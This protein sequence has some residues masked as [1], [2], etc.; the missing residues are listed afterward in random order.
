MR[1]QR[2]TNNPTKRT[3]TWRTT[4]STATITAITEKNE[5]H[6]YRTAAMSDVLGHEVCDAVH[7]LEAVP[8]MA[9]ALAEALF[10]TYWTQANQQDGTHTQCVENS[11]ALLKAAKAAGV[12]RIVH[13]SIT[14]ADPGSPLP[15]FRSKGQIEEALRGLGVS[16]AILRPSVQYAA[17]DPFFNH[18]AWT[19]RRFPSVLLPSRSEF[20]LRPI[21]VQDLAQLAAEAAVQDKNLEIDAVGPEVFTY[22][23]MVRLGRDRIGA[24]CLVLTAP[25]PLS[26]SAGRS[27]R[28]FLNE[29]ALTHA[30]AEGLSAGL[31]VS[32]SDGD[33]PG[34]TKLTDWLRQN[35]NWPGHKQTA[36]ID[37]LFD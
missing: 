2:S 15:Y 19:M 29:T 33:P 26:Y 6:N 31:L 28:F 13:L 25:K 3:S 1:M 23:E 36:H 27:V 5:A 22:A 7:G 21:F 16:Y 8:A 34:H 35:A 9:H 12:R 10:N 20:P 32:H 11:K 24:N 18:L 17:E 30:E 37:R 4:L 14:N